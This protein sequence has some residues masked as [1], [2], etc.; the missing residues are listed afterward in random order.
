MSAPNLARAALWYARHGWPVFPLRAHTKE[1]YAGIGVYQADTDAAQVADWWKWQSYANIGFHPGGAGALALDA[2]TYKEQCGGLGVLTF[3]EQET[4]T[5]LTGSGGSHLVYAVPNGVRYGNGTGALP[6]GLEIRSWG[7]YIVLP[8]SVHPNGRRYVWE[9][10][11]GPHEHALAPL[12][13]SLQRA[14]QAAHANRAADVAPSDVEAMEVAC[15]IVESVLDAAQVAHSG[16][17][18]WF[19]GRKWVFGACPFQPPLDPHAEDRGAFAVVLPD[20]RI[21]AGC[22]HNRCRARLRELN[23]T[24]WRY[25]KRLAVTHGE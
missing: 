2:D 22:Q 7:G 13:D 20:G 8:P 16:R 18:E 23:T 1:P 12:P 11:Y 15:A 25:L 6:E 4:V 14:L 17:R 5:R 19:H 24:G 9:A 21:S 3:E 10:G